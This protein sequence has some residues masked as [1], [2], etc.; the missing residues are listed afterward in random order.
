MDSQLKAIETH[1]KGY[2]FRS[3][4]EARWAVLFDALLVT[5]EYEKEG[6]QL[7]NNAG[8]YLPDFWLPDF[9]MWVEVKGGECSEADRAKIQ[10][11]HEQSGKDVVLVGNIPENSTFHFHTQTERI[12]ALYLPDSAMETAINRMFGRGSTFW[13]GEVSVLCPECGFDYVHIGTAEEV[14]GNDNYEAGWGGRGDAVRV[15]MWCEAGHSWVLRFG[16]HKGQTFAAIEKLEVMTSD[17][18]TILSGG[19]GGAAG[20]A[21]NAARS[22]RFE[23]GEKP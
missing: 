16:F 18:L 12:I 6:Y 13:D 20:R 15:G 2:R 14:N 22:A 7:L 4:L 9:D 21:C 3:R 19:R 8:F 5:W 17:L 10:A 1:Y 23:H 11:L